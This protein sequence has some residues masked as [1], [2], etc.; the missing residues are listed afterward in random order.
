MPVF[1]LR[2]QGQVV[3]TRDKIPKEQKNLNV[4]NSWTLISY[5]VIFSWV[6]SKSNSILQLLDVFDD[7]VKAYDEGYQID[8]T[9]LV[10]GF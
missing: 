1:D 3:A 2:Y 8:T 10:L 9:Y 5:L 4:S 7:R 6:C